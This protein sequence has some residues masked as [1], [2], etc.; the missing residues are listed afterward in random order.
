MRIIWDP[1]IVPHWKNVARKYATSPYKH[2]EGEYFRSIEY[3][4]C[5]ATV[6][7]VADLHAQLSYV[8]KVAR[9]VAMQSFM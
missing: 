2:N 1:R 5:G 4:V 7:N 3:K 8:D 6:S 9:S